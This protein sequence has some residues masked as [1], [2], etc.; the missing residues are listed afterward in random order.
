MHRGA[1]SIRRYGHVKGY[2]QRI[3]GVATIE[4][5]CSRRLRQ[6]EAGK[7]IPF[8]I[9]PRSRSEPFIDFSCQWV[10]D[11]TEERKEIDRHMVKWIESAKTVKSF[12]PFSA[13]L[14][15]VTF[16]LAHFGIAITHLVLSKAARLVIDV[17]LPWSL[18]KFWLRMLDFVPYDNCFTTWQ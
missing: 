1:D 6:P 11:R 16:R 5:E 15:S 17:G 3:S 12:V 4:H 14:R 8:S 18:W 10:P 7:L 13:W 2:A 9:R